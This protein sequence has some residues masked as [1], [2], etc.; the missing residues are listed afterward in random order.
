MVHFLINKNLQICK[1][2]PQPNKKLYNGDNESQTLL[3][4]KAPFFG[5]FVF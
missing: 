4:I 3:M 1:D 2:A 5:A